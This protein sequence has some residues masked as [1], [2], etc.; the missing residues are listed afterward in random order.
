MTTSL[1][2]HSNRKIP[3]HDTVN[4]DQIQRTPIQDNHNA[5]IKIDQHNQGNLILH[6]YYFYQQMTGAS[7]DFYIREEVLEKLH[8]ASKNLPQGIH[9]ML[10]DSWRP[11]TLQA[12]LVESF[13]AEIS[14]RYPNCS[15]LEKQK[16]LSLFVSAPSLDPQQPSPHMT[17]GSVDVTLCDDNGNPL[18]LGTAFDSPVEQSWTAALEITAEHSAQQLRRI[19]YWAMI[20]AGFS[21]LPSEW[22]HFDFGNQLWAYFKQQPHAH[23]LGIAAL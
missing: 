18:D 22:W 13:N 14:Q 15:A 20:D 1:H 5:L 8:L 23:Y 17:G 11:Y 16:I 2:F 3:Q 21:N 4:W 7:T 6:P 19:L 9:L 12:A 10:L